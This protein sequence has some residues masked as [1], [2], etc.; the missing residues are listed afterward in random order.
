[1]RKILVV[2][3][4]DSDAIRAIPLIHCLHTD[5]SI[6]TVVCIATQN[7]QLLAGELASFGFLVDENLEL[8]RQTENADLSPG[9]DRVIGMHKPNYVLVY[10][11]A[12]T[13][14]ASSSRY[15]SFGCL[16]GGLR[17]YELQ[18]HNAGNASAR[19]FDLAATQYFVSSETSRASLLKQGIAPENI[20]LTDSTEVDAALMLAERIHNDDGLKTK[21]A[22]DFSFLDPHK[23]LILVAGCRQASHDGYFE[24]LSLALKRLAKRSDLQVVCPVYPDS[25]VDDAI[26]R[27]FANFSNVAFIQPQDYLHSVYLMQSA[28]FILTEPG[29]IPK[30]ALS[31]CK[32]VLDVSDVSGRQEAET[33]DNRVNRDAG[34]ILQECTMLLDDPSYYSICS[35]H[36]NPYGDGHASERI[37][38]AMLR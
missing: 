34:R 21:L 7:S 23:R 22:A 37:V 11:D 38:E 17:L 18:H 10:G 16:G 15:A 28:Y 4:S 3:G 29:D 14:M 13:S 6:Q 33:S 32:P 19:L 2:V 25:G 5:P 20:F 26:D 24:S 8:I 31:L 36:R 30:E 9:V 12:C 35:L 1:M 27:A